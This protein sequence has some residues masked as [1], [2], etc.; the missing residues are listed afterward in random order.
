M[1]HASSEQQ[2]RRVTQRFS[3]SIPCSFYCREGFY[4]GIAKNLSIDGAFVASDESPPEGAIGT[5]VFKSKGVVKLRMP[6]KVVHAEGSSQVEGFGL[7][8]LHFGEDNLEFLEE[9][10]SE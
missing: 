10:T 9:L 3:G 1:S 6:S 5:L 8:F 7:Y 2:D 4:S